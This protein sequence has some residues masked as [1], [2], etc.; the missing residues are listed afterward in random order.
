MKDT[1]IVEAVTGTWLRFP[2]SFKKFHCLVE[3][4]DQLSLNINL[5][6]GSV[7]IHK[8]DGNSVYQPVGELML[9]LNGNQVQCAVQSAGLDLI[10]RPERQERQERQ[11][12]QSDAS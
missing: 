12:R 9:Q 7:H 10:E 2:N 4:P 8:M 3:L 11:V 5:K 6:S 1:Q